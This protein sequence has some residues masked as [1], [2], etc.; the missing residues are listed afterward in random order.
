MEFYPKKPVDSLIAYRTNNG[1]KELE[2]S[3]DLVLLIVIA[4]QIME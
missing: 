1:I 3:I 4:D 2:I